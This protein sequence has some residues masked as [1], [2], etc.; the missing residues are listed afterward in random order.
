MLVQHIKRG[1]CHGNYGTAR[2]MW[3]FL[4]E[5]GIFCLKYEI[6]EFLS[7]LLCWSDLHVSRCHRISGVKGVIYLYVLV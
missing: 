7:R 4:L 5:Y 6:D 3:S 1:C 2:S